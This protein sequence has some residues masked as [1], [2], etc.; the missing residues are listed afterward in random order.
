[1]LVYAVL[2][3][4]AIECGCGLALRTSSR[5]MKSEGVSKVRAPN[6]R[7]AETH[8]PM[9]IFFTAIALNT[10]LPCYKM[11]YIQHAL[12]GN[13]KKRPYLGKFQS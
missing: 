13:T 3:Q 8:D 2:V 6:Y 12:I 4:I 11:E 5:R 9:G 10:D 7:R 1:M